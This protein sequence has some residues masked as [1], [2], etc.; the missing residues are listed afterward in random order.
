M[1][2][3]VN[4]FGTTVCGARGAISW[5]SA[6]WYNRQFDQLDCDAVECVC[7][8]YLPLI[9]YKAVHIF[10]R[11]GE[12]MGQRYHQMPIRQ[13]VSLVARAFVWRWLWVLFVVGAAVAAFGWNLRARE[14]FDTES[15]AAGV[16]M[17]VAALCG[18][19]FLA[20]SDRRNKLIRRVLGPTTLGSSDPATWTADTLQHVTAAQFAVGQQTF[21]G[22]A[23]KLLQANAF[24]QAMR[25]ARYCVAIENRF[26]GE[27]LTDEI[28]RHPTVTA[29]LRIVN[30]DPARWVEH[31]D[32]RTAHS[33]AVVT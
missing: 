30:R 16:G 3:T 2:G 20:W 17:I 19:W 5:S 11:S 22:A 10:N 18:W 6:P 13:S 25:A 14:R 12:F 24:T 4:G 27:A 33:V 21:A 7:A 8:L 28:L 29:A 15:V 32:E 26:E 23:R 9:P 31:F 1:P